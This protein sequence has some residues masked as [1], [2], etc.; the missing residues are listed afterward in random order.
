MAPC[1]SEPAAVEGGQVCSSLC[2]RRISCSD[3]SLEGSPSLQICDEIK[4]TWVTQDNNLKSL[5]LITRE[6]FPGGS[7]GKESACIAGDPSS[8]PGLEDPLEK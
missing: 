1:T 4:P 5:N 3:H 6:I 2:Y 8:I 7:G